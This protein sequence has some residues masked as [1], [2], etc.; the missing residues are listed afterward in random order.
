MGRR[1]VGIPPSGCGRCGRRVAVTAITSFVVQRSIRGTA[2]LGCQAAYAALSRGACSRGSVAM[3]DISLASQDPSPPSAAPE[4]YD[5]ARRTFAPAD[6]Q[7]APAAT[8]RCPSGRHPGLIV[9]SRSSP[10]EY[11]SGP[12][13]R[14]PQ[15]QLSVSGRSPER[16][17]DQQDAAGQDDD[18]ADQQA[19]CDPGQRGHRGGHVDPQAHRP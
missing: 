18:A 9:G 5:L 10:D 7:R 12:P 17:R 1:R 8:Q 13:R 16:N 14:P 6:C 2:Q 19:G 15:R 11:Q 4:P 3:A